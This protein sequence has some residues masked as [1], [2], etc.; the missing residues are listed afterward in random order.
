MNT[1]WQIGIQ[2]YYKS[3]RN[4]ADEA[5]VGNFLIYVPF[6]FAR[7]YYYGTE[8]SLSYAKNGFTTYTNLGLA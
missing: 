4:Y 3:V 6:S 2:G 8:L 1:N 5:P 7:G